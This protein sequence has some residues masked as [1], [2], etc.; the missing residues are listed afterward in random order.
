MSRIFH[1]IALALAT[2][3]VAA[4]IAQAATDPNGNT[5]ADPLAVSYLQGQGMS[6]GE[7]KAATLEAKLRQLLRESG[8][9]PGP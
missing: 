8:A 7:I 6:P 1:L 4:P 2:A 3:A 9:L 5:V